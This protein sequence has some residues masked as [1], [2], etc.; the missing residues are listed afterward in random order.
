M[1]KAKRAEITYAM[2]LTLYALGFTNLFLRGSLGI[3][4]PSLTT[5]MQLTPAMLSAVASSFFF[6][7]AAMQI[8]TGMLLDRFGPRKTLAALLLFTALGAGIFAISRSAS[9]LIAARVL[10]GIGCAGIFTGAFYVLNRWVEPQHVV[11]QSGLL[12]SIASIGGLCATTPLAALI[13]LIGWRESYWLFTAGVVLLL[14]AVAFIVRDD[15]HGGST[16]KSST[17]ETLG[18]VFRGVAEAIRQPGMKRL[19]FVGIPLASQTTLLGAWAAP[20]LRDV[21]ALGPLARGNVLL[22]MAVCSIF[23]HVLYGMLARHFN[24]IRWVIF[25]GMCLV[26][27]SLTAMTLMTKPS[28]YLVAPLFCVISISTMYPMLAFAHSRGLVPP[29]LVGRGVAVANMGIMTAIASSQM[30]FGWVV[31][32]FPLEPSGMSPEIAYRWA[33]GTLAVLSVAAAAI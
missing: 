5:E 30:L 26:I 6:A 27:M 4:G 15:P 1:L 7:Y 11:T 18:D 3:L 8:P 2:L 17:T 28:I 29:H 9:E 20:Y 21:H 10:M 12:N 24:S 31:G 14:L 16:A 19:I 25:T 22:A 32:Q 33:F 13:G 23:G